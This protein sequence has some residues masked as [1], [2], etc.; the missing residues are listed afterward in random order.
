VALSQQGCAVLLHMGPGWQWEGEERS[1][2]GRMCQPG[3]KK[4]EVG[5]AR[6][7]WIFLFSQMN[8]KLVQ[9][10]LIKR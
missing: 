7:N 6:M 1:G 2:V 5:R 9:I 4:I 10:V 8:F 3:R